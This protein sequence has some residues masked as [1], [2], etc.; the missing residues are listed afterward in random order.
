MTNFITI[1]RS[2]ELSISRIVGVV[3]V[4]DNMIENYNFISIEPLI[5]R[6]LGCERHI[7]KLKHVKLSF[8]L[9][10]QVSNVRSWS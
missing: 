6:D 2:R 1:I 10:G 9:Q 3:V 4:G 8:C 5:S 7:Y